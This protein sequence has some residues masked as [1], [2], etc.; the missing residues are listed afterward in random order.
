[1]FSPLWRILSKLSSDQ[2]THFI[3]QIIK[4]LNKVIQTLWH[5]PPQ[6][7]GKAEHTNGILKSKLAKL[8]ETTGLPWPK[9]LLLAIM[10][11]RSTP[12]G[13]TKWIPYKII[14]GCPMLLMIE[15][16]GHPAHVNSNMT[17]N[18]KAL[19]QYSKAHFQLVKEGFRDRPSTR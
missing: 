5:Y 15:P 19:M 2:G 18:C 7:S 4:Q 8:T 11:L 14:T 13:E 3:G 6:S 12:F 9:V 17:Q 16:H 10:T 1:M